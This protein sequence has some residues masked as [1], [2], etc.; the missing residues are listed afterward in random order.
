MAHNTCG[1]KLRF[2]ASRG[3]GERCTACLVGQAAKDR[4][5]RL[6][7]SNDTSISVSGC[8]VGENAETSEPCP[9]TDEGVAPEVVQ[10]LD[11]TTPECM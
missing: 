4:V 5:S 1:E 7:V 10:Q 6:V 8:G 3:E 2:V 9:L 11:C